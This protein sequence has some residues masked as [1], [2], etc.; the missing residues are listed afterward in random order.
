[1][2]ERVVA[3]A[4]G[5]IVGRTLA[6]ALASQSHLRPVLYT[7]GPA[8]RD[9]RASAVSAAAQA[10]LERIGIWDKVLIDSQPIE[11]MRITDSRADD[12][13]R[14]EVLTF[15]SDRD[16]GAFSDM[17]PNVAMRDALAARCEA[18]NIEVSEERVEFFE[19][20]R[21]GVSLELSGGGIAHADIL[22][23]ADGRDS[24]LRGIAGIE[25]V[26]HDYRQSGIVCTVEHTKPHHGVATQHFLPNGPFA[27]LPLVGNRSSIVWTERPSFAASLGRTD[28]LLAGLEIERVFGLSLGRLTVAGEIQVFPLVGML[29]RQFTEGRFALIGDA[30]H[31][32]H[33]LAGQG[34]NLGLR[35]VAALTETLVDAHRAGE[36]L[37]LALPRCERWRRADS[38]QMAL[39]TGGLNAIFSQRS[40]FIRAIR[41]IG[42]GLVEQRE[43]LKNAFIR[44]AA[45]FAG[46]LPRLMKG[47]A[48]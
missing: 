27:M 36:D 28:P 44:E 7:G 29:A 38:T 20:T 25:V 45:G 21:N 4:G 9:D 46:E 11:E 1:M 17:V 40:D 18:L 48:V 15:A 32:I 19:E 13:I 12:A 39:V 31:V 26:T 16:V 14:P 33:P 47:E 34:L 35:D 42:I 24:K 6:V 22:I 30:A 8:K 3:I 43:D 10:M 2:T 37:S 41:S 23:A 5:G